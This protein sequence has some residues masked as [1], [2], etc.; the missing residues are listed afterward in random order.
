PPGRR[1]PA[2]RSHLWA[3]VALVAVAAAGI[4][5]FVA[6]TRNPDHTPG[7][8][9]GSPRSHASAPSVP[10]SW[11]TYTG[12][13]W[14]VRYPP[15]WE[16]GSYRGQTQL[17][18]PATHRTVRLGPTALGGS[19]LSLLTSTASSFAAAY[20]SYQQLRLEQTGDGAVWELTYSDGGADLHAVDYAFTRGGRGFTAFTQAKAA[21]WEAAAPE[22]QQV[23]RSLT[24]R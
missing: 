2:R 18:D 23:V 13:G 21:D 24:N 8:A 1:R 12:D 10:A 22:L 11:Q 7:T 6:S 5:G 9:K 3:P 16:V 14:S 20:A 4:T 19:P 17:R 15:G